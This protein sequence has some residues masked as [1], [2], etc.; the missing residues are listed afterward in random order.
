[1]KSLPTDKRNS[2]M[3]KTTL[4][5]WKEESKKTLTELQVYLPEDV[6]KTLTT[7][8]VLRTTSLLLSSSNSLELKSKTRNLSTLPKER[9][10]WR[11]LTLS[12]KFTRLV[13]SNN[14]P[15]SKSNSL[16]PPLMMLPLTTTPKTELLTKSDLVTLITAKETLLLTNS[17]TVKER[18]GTKS[19]KKFWL[20]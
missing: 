19:N 6:N 17:K 18:D 12:Y 2:L 15:S 10:S 1:M 16:I 9:P 11:T 7:L 13:L 20:S 5:G 8:K 4:P 14:F 3:L